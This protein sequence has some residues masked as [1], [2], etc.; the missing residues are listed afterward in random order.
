MLPS[1]DV[2]ARLSVGNDFSVEGLVVHR[3]L[4]NAEL[5]DSFPDF[6]NGVHRQGACE[7]DGNCNEKWVGSAKI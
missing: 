3:N 5:N 7:C 4:A 1:D 2:Q 6:P